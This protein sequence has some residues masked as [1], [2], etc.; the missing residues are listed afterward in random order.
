MARASNEKWMIFK[1]HFE[2]GEMLEK[3]FTNGIKYIL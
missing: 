1:I 3:K 2:L